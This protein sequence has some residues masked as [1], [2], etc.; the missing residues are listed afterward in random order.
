MALLMISRPTRSL[1]TALHDESSELHAACAAMGRAAAQLVDR[2]KVAGAIRPEVTTDELL[3]LSAAVSSAAH[4][5][6]DAPEGIADRLL[7]LAMSGVRA[8]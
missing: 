1:L 7:S 6:P 8:R 3:M 2:A 4:G 5:I